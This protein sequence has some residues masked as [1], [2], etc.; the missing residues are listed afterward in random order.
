MSVVGFRQLLRLLEVAALHPYATPDAVAALRQRVRLGVTTEA[1]PAA[2]ATSGTAAAWKT[3]GV[4]IPSGA[5]AA[6]VAARLAY[7]ENGLSLLTLEK[8]A[9]LLQVGHLLRMLFL[10]LS[11]KQSQTSAETG[12]D[13][14][15]GTQLAS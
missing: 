6:D 9:Q 11:P 2:N 8:G 3:A 10:L 5:V 12:R 15:H 4:P 7:V 14:G 1:A 13:H